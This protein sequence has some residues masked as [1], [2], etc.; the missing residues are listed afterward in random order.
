MN[1]A[2]IDYHKKYSFVSI[3]D[4]EGRTVLERQVPHNDPRVF[5]EIFRQVGET[6]VVYECGLNWTWLY[7]VL[8]KILEVK[9]IMLANA[10]KVRLIAEA[11]IKTD[12][13]D[14]RKLAMLLGVAGDRR[15]VRPASPVSN[16]SHRRS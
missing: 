13:L 14:A 1:Y 8:E 11:Q 2:G 4:A 16:L 9:R 12:K 6:T 3:Q 10:F 5:A 7:E 15:L